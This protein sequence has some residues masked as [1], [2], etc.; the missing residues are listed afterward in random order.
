M[1]KIF[2]KEEIENILRIVK[3]AGEILKDGFFSLGKDIK[4]KEN[5]ELVTKYDLLSEEF[6]L[7]KLSKYGFSFYSEETRQNI[8][9]KKDFWCIDPLDGTN[10]FAY[11]IPH[12]AIS[13]A[14]ILEKKVVLGIVYDP[15]KKDLFFAEKGNGAF[16]NNNK[17]FVSKRKCLS[18]S[19]VASG[20]PYGRK[21]D[22]ENNLD[23]IK[24]VA[25]EVKGFRRMGSAALDLA[26]V[27]S[28]RFDGY[29]EHDLK[30]W[31]MAA[32][33]LLVDEANGKVSCYDKSDWNIEK[34]EILATNGII[35]NELAA[36]LGD[37]GD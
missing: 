36:L 17:L 5:R 32:G 33:A 35:H 19:M 11:G 1:N 29:W 25:L 30:S 6:L 22:N 12:F 13:V 34:K 15:L 14:L 23:N 26:Y 20:L 16:L 24:R 31:D 27:A 8:S 18:D 3:E 9:D 21:I 7:N 2:N 37:Y 28:G 10:N 4:T